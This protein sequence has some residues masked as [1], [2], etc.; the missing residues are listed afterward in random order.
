MIKLRYIV[1]FIL[2]AV[3][4]FIV[5]GATNPLLQD[6]TCERAGMGT[7]TANSTRLCV[8]RETGQVY[9]PIYMRKR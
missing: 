9:A 5:R 1:L 4:G 8:D 7:Y 3:F 2:I 6:E